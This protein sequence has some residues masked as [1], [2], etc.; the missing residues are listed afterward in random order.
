[1]S[2]VEKH[3]VRTDA[4]RAVGR[5]R[6]GSSMAEHAILRHLGIECY[7]ERRQAERSK[8]DAEKPAGKGFWG[9]SA[10]R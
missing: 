5:R 3:H 2:D 10:D 4:Q 9:G 1:M 8:D 7:K 6:T